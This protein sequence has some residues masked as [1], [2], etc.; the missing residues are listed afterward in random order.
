MYQYAHLPKDQPLLI[1]ICAAANR[2]FNKLK[3][4]K[5]EALAIS[6][7]N[8]RYLNSKISSLTSNIQ[9][10]SY[11]LAWSLAKSAVPTNKFSLID[12]GGGSGMLSLLAKELGLG[13]VIYNDIYDISCRDAQ[14]I[15]KSLGVE[16]DYYVHGNIDDVLLFLKKNNFNCNAI[17]SYDVIEHIYNVEDFFNKVSFLTNAPIAIVMSSG[18]NVFNPFIRKKLMKKQVELE[19]KDQEKKWGH[20]ERDCLKAYLRVRK[21][22]ILEYLKDF[23]TTLSENETEQ[24]VKNTRGMIKSKIRKC[25]EDYLKTGNFPPPPVHPTNTCDPYTGNWAEHLMDPFYLANILSNKGF[26]VSI[27]SGYYGCP[28]NTVKRLLAKILNAVIFLSRK[29]GLRIAPFYTIYGKRF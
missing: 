26:T 15:A 16:A 27:L 23:N 10:Y 29:Q 12:Y 6:D 14:Q 3:L 19:Y 2:L 21:E 11:I 18:A 25:V 9:L 5:V 24:L 7:Y 17:V 13:T 4:L 28:K 22:M 20:K 1:D 8:K